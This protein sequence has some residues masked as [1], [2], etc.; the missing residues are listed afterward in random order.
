MLVGPAKRVKPFG[1]A[2]G[3]GLASLTS[4]GSCSS[5]VAQEPELCPL[6]LPSFSS[7]KR[8]F[9]GM[10]SPGGAL[11]LAG[12]QSCCPGMDPG[13]QKLV[14]DKPWERLESLCKEGEPG[15]VPRGQPALHTTAGCEQLPLGSAAGAKGQPGTLCSSCRRIRR[16]GAAGAGALLPPDKGPQGW[17]CHPSPHRREL[18]T[19]IS[20]HVGPAGFSSDEGPPK[21]SRLG[22]LLP[23]NDGLS[24][25]ACL[26]SLAAGALGQGAANCL[27]SDKMK[28]ILQ[29]QIN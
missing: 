24:A 13:T 19:L 3:C 12:K 16:V 29:L 4:C 28:H 2:Q 6:Q 18:I 9:P 1:A 7:M 11:C 25:C 5:S 15:P 17:L 26:S 22:L 23:W 27:Q 14:F 21:D 10:P 8:L 20:G